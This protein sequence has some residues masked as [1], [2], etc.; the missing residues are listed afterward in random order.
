MKALFA[1]DF[2]LG[3]PDYSQSRARETKVVNFLNTMG[4]DVSTIYLMG[5]IFDYWFEYKSVVPKG[6]VRLLGCLAALAD[7]G[8]ALKIFSGNHD[9]WMKGYFTQELGAEVYHHPITEVLDGQRF[10]LA[11]GDG[12]GPGDLGYKNLKRL[13]RNPM[14]Q[15][16]YSQLHPDLASKIATISSR[17]SRKKTAGSDAI[18]LG[19][20]KEWL[21]M[22][23]NFVLQ[24]QHIDY[25]VYGHR[26]LPMAL[27]LGQKSKFINLGDWLH[28]DTF[29]L[30]DSAEFSLNQWEGNTFTPFLNR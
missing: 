10:Y 26:H 18:F 16:A 5:D 13:F 22:H 23:S 11:H 4:A 2:H 3:A 14:A 12:L 17:A 28:Y 9:V 27:P 15:W 19:A 1:S 30:W 24:S 8:K 21:I 29:G 25:F 20:D 7:S 6:Y